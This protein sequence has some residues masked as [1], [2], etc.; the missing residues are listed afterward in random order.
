MFSWTFDFQQDINELLPML[1]MNS[2]QIEKHHMLFTRFIA[3]VK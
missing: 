2:I 3:I 1:S